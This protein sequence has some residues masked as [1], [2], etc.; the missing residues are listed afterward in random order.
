MCLSVTLHIV[1]LWQ[2]YVC[3][4]RSGVTH[5]TL[6][7]VLFLCRICRCGLHAAAHRF[8]YAPPR[9]RTS[10]YSRTFFPF[11]YL[12]GTILVTPYSMVW[13]WRVSRAGPMCLYWPICSLPFCLLLFSLSL[14]SFYELV[15][16]G[17]GLRTDRVL[18]ALP[19]LHYQSLEKKLSFALKF[20]YLKFYH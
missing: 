15:L 7:M 9:C 18:I 20:N 19:A 17:L 11:Q 14:L 16:W 6:F 5:C 2:Y 1:D 8:T 10:Q 13:D 12:C 3:C 4:T